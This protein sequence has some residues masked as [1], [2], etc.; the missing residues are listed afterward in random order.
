MLQPAHEFIERRWLG[1]L[2]REWGEL[3]HV[4]IIGRFYT[5]F[6]LLVTQSARAAPMLEGGGPIMD[7]YQ[8]HHRRYFTGRTCSLHLSNTTRESVQIALARA[9]KALNEGRLMSPAEAMAAALG[10]AREKETLF[11]IARTVAAETGGDQAEILCRLGERY[12]DFA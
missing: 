5:I 6:R 7:D 3:D 12:L 10:E 4:P 1:R 2:R 11:S 9:A 8:P